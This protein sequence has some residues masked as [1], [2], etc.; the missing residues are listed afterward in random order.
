MS[1]QTLRILL[2]G[3][4]PLLMHS[5]RLADPLDPI[6]VELARLDRQAGQDNR[7]P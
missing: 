7:R 4:R 3:D 6:T 5:A 2:S 1:I